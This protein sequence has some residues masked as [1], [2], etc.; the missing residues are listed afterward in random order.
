MELIVTRQAAAIALILAEA[1]SY[2]GSISSP[3]EP[4][5]SSIGNTNFSSDIGSDSE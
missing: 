4:E 2:D 3:T 1:V 5:V